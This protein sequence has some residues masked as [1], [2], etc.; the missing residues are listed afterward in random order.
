MLYNKCEW[1]SL[2]LSLSLSVRQRTARERKNMW[3]MVNVLCEIAELEVRFT[4]SLCVHLYI[5]VFI[6]TR[7]IQCHST[8]QTWCSQAAMIFFVLLLY[9]YF[10]YIRSFFLVVLLR[11]CC[12]V[13]IFVISAE[14]DER[15]FFLVFLWMRMSRQSCRG[16]VGLNELCGNKIWKGY[17]TYIC[18]EVNLI[19]VFEIK[20]NY[21]YMLLLYAIA[22][23]ESNK[24]CWKCL[25]RK[26]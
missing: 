12:D 22:N 17:V 7:Y 19:W 20:F 1:C 3:V 23:D 24:A 15:N 9:R 18:S 2:A 6:F 21:V 25:G 10:M 8:W 14:R 11:C 13:S 26:I 5:D 4:F 16:K